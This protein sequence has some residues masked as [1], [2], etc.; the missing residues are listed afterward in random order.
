MHLQPAP[1]IGSGDEADQMLFVLDDEVSPQEVVKTVLKSIRHI[2]APARSHETVQQFILL[3]LR[4]IE[5]LYSTFSGVSDDI[6]SFQYRDLRQDR[7]LLTRLPTVAPGV[8]DFR[9]FGS[10]RGK[11]GRS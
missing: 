8:D 3:V 2:G 1:R 5:L 7:C 6:H 9:E 10:Q 4:N 11:R